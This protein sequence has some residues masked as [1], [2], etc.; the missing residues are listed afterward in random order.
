MKCKCS[1][2]T[3]STCFSVQGEGFL[4]FFLLQKLLLHLNT[5][6][7]PTWSSSAGKQQNSIL[8]LKTKELPGEEWDKSSSPWPQESAPDSMDGVL[9]AGQ[10]FAHPNAER[11][12]FS[13]W[14]SL[15]CLFLS[16]YFFSFPFLSPFLSPVALPAVPWVRIQSSWKCCRSWNSELE[17]TNQL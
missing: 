17:R 13:P 1:T 3:Q 5:P 15:S 7:C 14:Q 4:S 6:Q 2:K 10:D 16:L 9:C 11:K 12:L 8:L